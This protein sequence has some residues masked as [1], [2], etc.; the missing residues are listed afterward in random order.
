MQ[1]L[2]FLS[3]ILLLGATAG[4]AFWCR[5]LRM[6]LKAVDGIDARLED[7]LTALGDKL[8]SLEEVATAAET[9]TDDHEARVKAVNADADDRIGRIEMLLASLEEIEEESAD[10][11]L[12]EP[13]HEEVDAMPSFRAARPA[14][15]GGSGR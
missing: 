13:G 5:A 2:S 8:R 7:R 3:D 15:F 11:L 10:R 9:S 1:P 6:R 14:A 12:Q 4:M